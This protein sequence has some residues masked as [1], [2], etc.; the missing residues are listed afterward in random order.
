MT[1]RLCPVSFR[2]A[3]DFVSEHHRHHRPPV[4]WKFG[5]GVEEDGRLAGVAMAGRPVAR[6]LD[7][8]RTLEVTRLCTDGTRNACS[9]LYSAIRRAAKALG[10]TRLVTYILETE[11]GTSLMAAGW[12]RVCLTAGGSWS[13][14]SRPR[15]DKAPTCRKV[16]WEADL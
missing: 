6:G 5:V 11:S 4:S 3:A 2:Q 13:C 10:Y 7:D 16:R 8:G 14:P 12:H 1:L 15:E 9:M